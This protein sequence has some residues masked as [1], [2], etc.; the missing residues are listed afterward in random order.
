MSNITSVSSNYTNRTT[1][2]NIGGAKNP[3]TGGLA[4]LTFEFG[5]TSSVITGVQKLVQR[6]CISLMTTL[7][8][9]ESTPTFGT[10]FATSIGGNVTASDI[11]HQLVFANNKIINEFREYQ[12]TTTLDLP[13]DEQIDTVTIK[14]LTYTV[15]VL[16][17]QLSIS[18]LAGNSVEYI[19]PLPDL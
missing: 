17:L 15:G 1:D 16:N 3:T 6:Y 14:S 5:A 13:L 9:Q 7:T 11:Y 12:R 10:A 18:T 4:K 2:I 8:S 19:L